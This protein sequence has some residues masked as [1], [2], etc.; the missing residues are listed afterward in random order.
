VTE[1]QPYPWPQIDPD[2]WKQWV[3][4]T[5]AWIISQLLKLNPQDYLSQ[6]PA[7][8]D[9]AIDGGE[10]DGVTPPIDGGSEFGP[11]AGSSGSGTDPPWSPPLQRPWVVIASRLADTVDV[12]MMATSTTLV[13]G[14]IEREVT[15]P[16]TFGTPQTD[17]IGMLYQFTDGTKLFLPAIRR[18][19]SGFSVSAVGATPEPDWTLGGTWTC[20]EAHALDGVQVYYLENLSYSDDG[21]A[22]L[23]SYPRYISFD[24]YGQLGYVSEDSRVTVDEPG[25]CT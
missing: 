24:E 19:V 13:P 14:A 11:D 21:D 6:D 1:H 10:G 23:Y 25:A 5:I 2:P 12:Q 4:K 18:P 15:V 9:S 3:E 8:E 7:D 17:D 16:A 22:K 20:D